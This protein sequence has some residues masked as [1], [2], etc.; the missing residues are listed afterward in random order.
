M[1][2][3][4][5]YYERLEVSCDASSETIRKQYRQLAIKYHPDKNKND[6]KAADKV[7]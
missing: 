1:V 4:T 7:L 5:L 6:P 3:E 2:K